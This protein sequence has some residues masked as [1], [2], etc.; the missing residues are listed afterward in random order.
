[1]TTE[2]TEAIP[3]LIIDALSRCGNFSYDVLEAVEEDWTQV[4]HMRTACEYLS[5]HC[6]LCQRSAPSTQSLIAHLRTMHPLYMNHVLYKA[7][8]MNHVEHQSPCQFCDATPSKL[9]QCPVILQLALV[10]LGMTAEPTQPGSCLLECDV[11]FETFQ[12]YAELK[13]HVPVAH[14]IPM[15]DFQWVRDSLRGEPACNHCQHLFQTRD[16]LKRE[17]LEV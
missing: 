2:R 8:L 7:A 5:K 3:I 15:F 4:Q 6:L 10:R 13:A 12:T 17:M 9:H 11:C 1:M 14:G 16:G